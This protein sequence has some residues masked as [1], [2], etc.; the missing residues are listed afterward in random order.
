VI[1]LDTDH[2]NVLQTPGQAG[3]TLTANMEGSLDRD[4]A[5]SVVTIEEQMRGWLALIHRYH[6]VHKQLSAYDRL[7][8]LFAFFSRWKI[9]GFDEAAADEFKRLRAQRIRI[10]TMDL[11]IAAIALV[12]DALLLSANFSDSRFQICVWRIG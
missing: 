2:V 9:V 8:K 7:V 4:F 10:G 3:A 5:T 6:D 11:K 12:N 1:I